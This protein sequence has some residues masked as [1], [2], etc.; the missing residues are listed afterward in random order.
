MCLAITKYSDYSRR[1]TAPSLLQRYVM[2]GCVYA[3]GIFIHIKWN[4][5]FTD[6]FHT[7]NNMTSYMR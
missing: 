3:I 4:F 2:L 7:W 1:D 5:G 6:I